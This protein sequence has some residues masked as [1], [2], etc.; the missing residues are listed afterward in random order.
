MSQ[1]PDSLNAKQWARRRTADGYALEV[2]IK[3]SAIVSGTENVSV[4]IDSVF[5]L[6]LNVHDN[7]DAQATPS[8]DGSV[9][10]AAR[11]VD[12][13][14]NTPAYLGTVKFLAD[15]KLQFIPINNISG[16]TNPVP[17]DGTPF[18]INVDGNRDPVFT[19]S[20]GFGTGYIQLQMKSYAGND[21]GIPAGDAD[22]SANVWTAWDTTWLYL[23]E[24][25]R[26]NVVSNNGATSYNNDGLELKIDPQ[27]T[28][29]T[30]TG[31]SIFAPNLTA[32]GGPN[33]DS[34]S[35]ITNTDPSAAKWSRRIM[36][37]GYALELAIKWSAITANSETITPAVDNVF[38]MAINDHDND[39]IPAQRD[40]S[41]MWAAVM[42]DHV[43]DTPKYLG[44]VKFLEDNKLQFIPTNNMTGVTNPTP[45]DGTPFYMVVDGTQDAF[46][47]TLT[48]PSNGY[49]QIRSFAY[50]QN[51][52]PSNDADLSAKVWAAWD[53][54]WL[55]MYAE[56]K[57][58]VVS[59]NGTTSYKMMVLS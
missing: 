2:A 37:G 56:V 44:T 24:E 36:N 43:W 40:A 26:D 14:W 7:D 12:A 32:L 31:S 13:V 18:Y 49:L 42:L 51:G 25:V 33:T 3:W 8:R 11:M 46:Y 15:N 55:Y 27:P 39:S 4:A 20:K 17:F 30:N 54:T 53:T 19:A 57:D 41:I 6:A 59:V 47:K 23:Y 38:G 1:I 58:T 22:L 50:N 28:D 29:S 34:L 52:A 45:Y 9:M 35:N 10:W 21:N 5:G 48:T 16:E